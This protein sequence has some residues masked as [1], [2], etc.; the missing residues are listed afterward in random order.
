MTR[1]FFISGLGANHLIFKNL[2]DFDETH[3]MVSWENNLPNE[4]LEDY[5]RRI[6]ELYEIKTE[7][8]IIGYSFGGVIAQ[9]IASLLAM[10]KVILI[11]SFR[12]KHDLRTFFDKA[13]QLKLHKLLLD[14]SITLISELVANYLK[15]G[16]AETKSMMKNMILTSDINLLRWSVDKIYHLEKPIGTQTK[17]YNLIGDRDELVKKWTNDNTYI[18]P[19][20]HHLMVY[21]YSEKLSEALNQI[22]NPLSLR[23]STLEIN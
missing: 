23:S 15:C 14:S 17:V 4:S 13:L 2:I 12:T 6:I 22:I 18:I 21:D 11:S 9:Q 3:I 10:E 1:Q 16:S 8:I 5:S 19:S 7:D 20:G